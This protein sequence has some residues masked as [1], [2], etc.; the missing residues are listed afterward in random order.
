MQARFVVAFG[1]AALLLAGLTACGSQVGGANSSMPHE[2]DRLAQL[3][4]GA[5]DV[6]EEMATRL[7]SNIIWDGAHFEL[8]GPLATTPDV[9]L[10][11]A[12]TT[13]GIQ[14][15]PILFAESREDPQAEQQI[16][17]AVRAAVTLKGDAPRSGIVYVQADG[18]W[19]VEKYRS[20]LPVGTVVGLYLEYPP[21]AGVEW[22]V[23]NPD[24]GRP[25]GEPL[26]Q[27][28]P[29]S[30]IVADGSRGGV[31]FPVGSEIA[32]DE[33]FISQLPKQV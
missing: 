28:G 33:T 26:W 6:P 27:V 23:G 24:A 12:G 4:A 21:Q 15:G 31:V 30:M 3:V 1:S 9:Q 32:R 10:I 25:H 5:P 16:V 18:N 11:V 29:R 20:G 17:I 14:S 13:E 8:P 2:D 7:W 22:P 19:P